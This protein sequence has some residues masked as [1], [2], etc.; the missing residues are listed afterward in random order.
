MYI[1]PIILTQEQV[2][3]A[4]VKQTED[5]IV[6]EIQHQLG[7]DIDKEELLKALNY[8]R[9]QYNE[10]YSDG[11]CAGYQ[12]ALNDLKSEI[13]DLYVGYRHGYEIMADVLRILDKLDKSGSE[14]E[15]E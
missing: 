9:N 1:A 8:D 15:Y 10:G 5:E 7:I 12:E 4:I 2:R 3:D 13:Q 11:K 6:C 14:E